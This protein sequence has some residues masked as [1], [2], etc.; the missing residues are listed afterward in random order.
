MTINDIISEQIENDFQ[1]F[2]QSLPDVICRAPGRVNLIG[3]HTD[4]NE[5]FVF[6][7]ALD[8]HTYVA[9][10][11]RNDRSIHVIAKDFD[12]AHSE[13]SL[14][15]IKK[16]LEEPW[17][18][19]VRGVVLR[20][21]AEH[22]FSFGADLIVTGTVP[23]AAGLSSSASFEIALVHAFSQLNSFAIEGIEA[24][25][26]GQWAENNFVGCSCGI[27]DQLISALGQADHALLLDCQSLTSR[28]IPLPDGYTVFI[29]NSNVQRELVDSEYNSRRMQCENAAKK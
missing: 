4:Y 14:D 12:F 9:A 29:V 22:T 27:M 21:M 16:D 1:Q 15:D 24:A 7:V 8:V 25:R 19:Y 6:P 2:F 28:H 20:L 13:F 26:I 11:K 17:S 10:K 5:G 23:K 3:E 18:N